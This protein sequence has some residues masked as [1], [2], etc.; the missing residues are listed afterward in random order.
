MI[1]AAL[2][3][4]C[5]EERPRPA[6]PRLTLILDDATVCSPD[7]VSGT[8]RADDPDG[9]DSLWVTV[10]QEESGVDGLL[11]RS[12][13]ARFRL[14]VRAGLSTGSTVDVLV[15]ARDLAGFEDTLERALAVISCTATT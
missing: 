6:P 4:A 3:A 9:I 12:F 5:L 11:E 2:G 7:T 15:R 1:G 14:P 13:E 8:V 10:D